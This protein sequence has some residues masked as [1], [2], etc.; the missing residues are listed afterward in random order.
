MEE[1]RQFGRH[2]GMVS[3]EG[4]VQYDTMKPMEIGEP[5]LQDMRE[6]MDASMPQQPAQNYNSMMSAHSRAAVAMSM[7]SPMQSKNSNANARLR[8]RIHPG[9]SDVLNGIGGMEHL[10]NSLH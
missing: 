4:E 7:P 2:D 6:S 8:G 10:S 1:E 9:A 5:Q 3:G